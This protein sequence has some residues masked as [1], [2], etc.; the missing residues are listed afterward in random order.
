MC[1]RLKNSLVTTSQWLGNHHHHL[2][3]TTQQLITHLIHSIIG[4]FVSFFFLSFFLQIFSQPFELLILLYFCN[5]FRNSRSELSNLSFFFLF[6]FVFF[7]K[8]IKLKHILVQNIGSGDSKK[9]R[10][11]MSDVTSQ[12]GLPVPRPCFWS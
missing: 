9:E 10:R 11:Q 12:L 8:L 1:V 3:P 2:H 5:H 6:F 7:D 4:Y